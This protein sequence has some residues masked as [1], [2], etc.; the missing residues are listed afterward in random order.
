MGV[1]LCLSSAMC[2]G[3][4]AIFGT[5]AYDDGVG[6]LEL[7]LVR[8]ALAAVLF[9]LLLAARRPAGGMLRALRG[10]RTRLTAFALGAVGYAAQ[11][12]LYFAA[13]QR[14]D[15][16]F[17]SLLLYTYPAMVT[18][19]ALLLGREAATPQRLAA[20]GAASGGVALVLA[21]AGPGDFDAIGAAMGVGAALVYTT[22]ILVAD[23]VVGDVDALPL[24]A[25]VAT[26]AATTFAVAG[27]ASGGV[28]LGFAAGGW[29]W[30]SCIAVVST[31]AAVLAFFAGLRR[32]GPSTAS[33]LSTFEPV[34]TIALAFACF[35]DRLAPVQLLG[36]T[37]VLA[38]V[39]ILQAGPA[40]RTAPV[41]QP[42][43]T[44]SG[45]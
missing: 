17:L 38:A 35:G 30:L 37:L 36:G 13:L 19:A 40:R 6:V 9:W 16:A 31:V 14:I 33:I 39:V 18:A 15:P 28:D 2:F 32:V 7:L 29:F 43:A 11:A 27:A 23:T 8:F 1:G 42:A 44:S 45:R 5:L 34:V 21:G 24:S 41:A 3:A 26:G 10:R 4:M 12:G 25:F 22:Y 20:L